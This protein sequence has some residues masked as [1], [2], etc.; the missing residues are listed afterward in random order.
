MSDQSIKLEQS[1]NQKIWQCDNH[2]LLKQLPDNKIDFIYID[3]PFCSQ[4]VQKDKTWG[5]KFNDEFKGG[6]YGYVAWLRSRLHDM[7]KKLTPTGMI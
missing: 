5:R 2:E 3:P 1:T 4:S 7:H 6:I